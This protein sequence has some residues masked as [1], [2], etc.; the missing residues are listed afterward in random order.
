MNNF[1]SCVRFEA[2]DNCLD[3]LN[4][5]LKEFSLPNGAA[6]HTVVKTGKNT[7]CTFI[8]WDREE[9]LANARPEMISYLDSIRHLLKE[10][11]PELGVTDPISGPVIYKVER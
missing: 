3:E 10:I 8:H 4:N 5:K 1:V 2:K 11:S 6:H 9:D 7:F